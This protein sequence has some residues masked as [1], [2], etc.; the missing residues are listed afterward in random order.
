MNG[1]FN[2]FDVNNNNNNSN[3]DNDHYHG[4]DIDDD[5]DDNSLNAASGCLAEVSLKHQV[6]ARDLRCL[7]LCEGFWLYPVIK[8][9]LCND[10]KRQVTPISANHLS[11]PFERVSIA[12]IIAPIM[13]GTIV[14]LRN[15]QIRFNS[16]LRPVLL[17]L[18]IIN[19]YYYNL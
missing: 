6:T 16:R 4:H 8:H 2:S 7:R 19:Y 3:N 14:T 18:I 13:T 9:A 17:L 5:D 11:M 10:S 1:S 15:F 12:V